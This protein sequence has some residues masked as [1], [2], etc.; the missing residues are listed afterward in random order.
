M[1]TEL[2][3]SLVRGDVLF[4]LQRAVGLIPPDGFGYVR[5][6]LVFALVAWLPIAVWATLT[7]RALSGMVNEPLLQ[8]FGVHV[9]CLVAIP[10][11]V[12]AEGVAHSVTTRLVP[13]FL[14]SGLVPEAERGRF[15]EIVGGVVRL[16]DAFHP[17]VIIAGI[18]VASSITAPVTQD[19]H[20]LVW[21]DEGADPTRRLGF[22]GMWFLYVA[23]PMFLALWLA[24]LW[25]VILAFVLFKRIARLELAIVPTHPDRLGGL[26]FLEGMPAAF[27]LVVLALSSVLASRWAH[28]IL[29]HA[30]TLKSLQLPAAAFLV[31]VAVL[32]LAPLLAFARPLRAARKRAL[33][34][35]GALVGEHGRRVRKRWILKEPVQDE[36]LLSAPEIGPVADTIALYEAVANMRTLPIGRRALLAVL[37]P[38]VLPMIAVA[39]LQVPIKDL[40]L[41]LLKVLA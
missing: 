20:E 13:H 39:A 25:R 22:G 4:R 10:L 38:A 32:F 33:L 21:A 29:Y 17:W 9:R 18:V 26:G 23:R 7:G 37:V 31:A 27:S 34:D 14:R 15:S 2:E 35:Y 12:I 28:E 19:M 24:W 11:F 1:K 36:E 8:H 16:R 40:L 3:L 5:R 30:A 41:G 6:A